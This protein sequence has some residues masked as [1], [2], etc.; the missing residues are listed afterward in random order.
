[1][2]LFKTYKYIFNV[3]KIVDLNSNKS[4]NCLGTQHINT[5]RRSQN[6]TV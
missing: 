3:Y 5:N 4:T 6:A 2:L 1:M